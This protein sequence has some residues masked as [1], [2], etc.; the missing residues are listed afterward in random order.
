M[1]KQTSNLKPSCI[2]LSTFFCQ[3]ISVFADHIFTDHIQTRL[4]ITQRKYKTSKD[5]RKIYT[6]GDNE[7]LV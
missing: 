3:R 4:K 6:K 1:I 5:G 7:I 2:C